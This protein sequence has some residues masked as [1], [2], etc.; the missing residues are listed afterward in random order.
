MTRQA[1]HMCAKV[2]GWL[3]DDSGLNWVAF[4]C[5]LQYTGQKGRAVKYKNT[6]LAARPL[7]YIFTF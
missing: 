2:L 1:P 5:K 4:C 6:H 7:K 3:L